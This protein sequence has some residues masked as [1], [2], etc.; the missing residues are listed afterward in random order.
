MKCKRCN[1]CTSHKWVGNRHYNYC[2]FC[3]LYYDHLGNKYTQ[4]EV[5]NLRQTDEIGKSSKERTEGQNPQDS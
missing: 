5:E 1:G 3:Y 4:I 2:D